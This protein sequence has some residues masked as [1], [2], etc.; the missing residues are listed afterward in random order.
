MK[1][2][3]RAFVVVFSFIFFG[4]GSLVL[5][6]VVIPLMSLFIK[7]ENRRKVF[8]R[9]VHNLWA[10]FSDFMQKTGSIKFNVTDEQKKFLTQLKGSVI[11]ANHPSYIDIV[12]LIG[13]IP[14]TLCVVK[15]EIKKNPIMSNIVKSTYLINDEN[16]DTLKKEAKHALSEG[17]NV[18]IF[19]TGTRSVEGEDLK[20]HS[21]AASVAIYANAPIVPVHIT[22]D[23]KFLAKHQ[24]I[25][26]AGEKP[27]NYYLKIKILKLRTSMKSGFAAV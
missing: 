14:D 9:V 19:P 3:F 26:D 21:G 27:V 11:V 5:G 13:L 23:Y 12:L 16:N 18:I 17:Y 15:N 6:L 7:K 2:F 22:C 20:L 4:A 24:K 1:R 25:Y 10:F 8:C